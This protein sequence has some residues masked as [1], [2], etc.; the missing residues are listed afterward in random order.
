MYLQTIHQ[1]RILDGHISRV[2]LESKK[3]LKLIEILTKDVEKEELEKL[4]KQLNVRYIIV[5]YNYSPTNYDFSL[6]NII[7]FIK[8]IKLIEKS[9]R[10]EVYEVS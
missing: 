6:L 8:S 1:K 10:L 7:K 3:T 4:L 9:E 5:D 2:N